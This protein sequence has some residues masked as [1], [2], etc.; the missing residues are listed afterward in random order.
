M[1]Y[2]VIEIQDQENKRQYVGGSTEGSYYSL[3]SSIKNALW[4]DTEEQA[5][6]VLQHKEFTQRVVFSGG[7][8]APPPLLWSGLGICNVRKTTD[9]F[10]NIVSLE[11]STESCKYVQ[12][13]LKGM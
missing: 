2:F 5:Q 7:S 1:K 13:E 6:E 8:S 9:G 10:I 12:D 3:T 11:V 4:F